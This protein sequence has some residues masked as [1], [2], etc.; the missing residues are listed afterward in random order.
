VDK[1]GKILPRV[2]ARQPAAPLLKQMQVVRAVRQVLGAEL[3]SACHDVTL[4]R[5][6]LRLA[7]SNPALARQLRHDQEQVLARVNELLRMTR[8]VRRLQVRVEPA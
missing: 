8:P 2:V 7:T 3:A 6:T 4:E 1:L 5:G